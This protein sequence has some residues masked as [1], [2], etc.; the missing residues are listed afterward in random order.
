MISDT[1]Y[2]RA[3]YHY[4]TENDTIADINF[5]VF[6]EVVLGFLK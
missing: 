5:P 4:H 2:V 3:P 6:S 1:A